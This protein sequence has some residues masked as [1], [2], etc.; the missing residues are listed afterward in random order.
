MLFTFFVCFF[1]I[2]LGFLPLLTN[3][4]YN[5]CL[6]SMSTRTPVNVSR[7]Q[8]NRLLYI[9]VY[10]VSMSTRTTVNVSRAQANRLLYM[11]LPC[12]NVYKNNSKCL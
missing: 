4:V 2:F 11:C 12:I 1:T 10:L 8:A 7:A 9:C 6:P 5:M 3:S